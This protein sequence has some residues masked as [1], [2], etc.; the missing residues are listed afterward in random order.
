M[1]DKD[2]RDLWGLKHRRERTRPGKKKGQEEP[3]GRNRRD[4]ERWR[5]RVTGSG[6]KGAVC[7]LY[8][9]GKMKDALHPLL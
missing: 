1:Y 4:R 3:H 9:L 2:Q 5:G 7:Q 6:G 8:N